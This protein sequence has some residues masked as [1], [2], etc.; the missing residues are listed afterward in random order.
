M[1]D[2][3]SDHASPKC[4][5]RVEMLEKGN[6]DICMDPKTRRGVALCTA[7]SIRRKQPELGLKE[8]LRKSYKLIDDLCKK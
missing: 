1:T 4:R 5:P 3:L 6:K 2:K 8:A 7:H